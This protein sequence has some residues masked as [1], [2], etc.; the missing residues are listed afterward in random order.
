MPALDSQLELPVI[1]HHH[2]HA[3]AASHGN[4]NNHKNYNHDYVPGIDWAANIDE[5][6]MKSRTFTCRL[7]VRR[8]PPL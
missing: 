2:H 6:W 7:Q 1:D 3:E 4:R 8:L 5:P